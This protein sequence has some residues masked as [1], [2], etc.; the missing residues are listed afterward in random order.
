VPKGYIEPPRNTGP[1]SK[2][3][4]WYGHSSPEQKINR[5]KIT[6]ASDTWQLGICFTSMLNGGE[7]RLLPNKYGIIPDHYGA[8][9]QELMF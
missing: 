8:E 3:K 2:G 7:L 6:F 1:N 4:Y 5:K 9:I